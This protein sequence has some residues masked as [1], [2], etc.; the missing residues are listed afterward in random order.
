MFMRLLQVKIKPEEL[1]NLSALYEEKIVP[2][3]QTVRGCL[4]AYLMQSVHHT[5]EVISMTLWRTEEDAAVYERGGLYKELL[6]EARPFFADSTEWKLQ[7]SKDFTLEYLP[8]PEEPAIRT[9]SVAST[10]E[11]TI[12][13]KEKSLQLFLRIV[14]VHLKPG[15]LEEYKELYRREIIPALQATRGC[16]YA[17]L[18]T[19]TIDSNEAIS[20]TLWNSR[21]DAEEYERSGRFDQLLHEVE[22]TLSDLSQWKSEGRFQHTVTSE[23]IAVEGYRLVAGKEF[24][25]KK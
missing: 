11:S 19:L 1:R 5:D 2:A 13:I 20:V 24:Q 25:N 16:L 7:L 6:E 15:K 17:C 3:L 9:F 14:S 4:Y 8:V 18:S 23:D 10:S 22:H 12:P 21:A